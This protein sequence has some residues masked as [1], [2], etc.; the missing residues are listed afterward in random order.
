M[1]KT[2][3]A[4]AMAATT[5]VLAGTQATSAQS[6]PSDVEILA[7]VLSGDGV[8]PGQWEVLR[9]REIKTELERHQRIG[10]EG[11]DVDNYKAL[12][13][14]G[15]RLTGEVA[16]ANDQDADVAKGAFAR[17]YGSVPSAHTSD[18]AW[19]YTGVEGEVSQAEYVR[20]CDAV[21]NSYFYIPGTETCLRIQGNVRAGVSWIE[22]THQLGGGTVVTNGGG[23]G[24]ENFA[25]RFG[26]YIQRGGVALDFRTSGD[27]GGASLGKLPV[28]GIYGGYE[29][30][31]GDADYAGDA[32]VGYDGVTGV[33]Y[34]YFEP[35]PSTGA[36]AGSA[37]FGIETQGHL[38]NSWN[39]ANFGLKVALPIGGDSDTGPRVRGRLGVFYEDLKTSASGDTQLTYNGSPYAG[40]SQQWDLDAKD[41]YYGIRTGVHVGFKPQLDGKLKTSIGADLYLGYHKG[42]GSYHQYSQAGGAPIMQMVDYSKNGFSVGG[43]LTASATYE[44]APGWK[45]GGEAEFSCLPGV[46][47]FFAPQNPNEQAEAGFSSERA[48]RFFL[49]ARLSRSF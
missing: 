6:A 21:G 44:F 12:F 18:T 39:R 16:K 45:L 5:I 4:A 49:R 8:G 19:R 11:Q 34:T 17:S 28:V 33:G 31:W 7:R 15:L 48:S 1:R 23:D 43:A 37:G 3:I 29:G 2:T 46:T 14:E 13:Q 35:E 25:A 24:N 41:Q 22:N 40:Y 30:A 20:V 32:M 26:D 38:D 10:I 42:E 47:S 36:I 9:L 27:Y